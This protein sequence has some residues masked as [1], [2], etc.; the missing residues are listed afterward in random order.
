MVKDESE[1]I[2]E[3]RGCQKWKERDQFMRRQKLPDKSPEK[4]LH[5]KPQK[6]Y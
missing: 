2:F 4:L 1:K 3:G 6:T 5:N